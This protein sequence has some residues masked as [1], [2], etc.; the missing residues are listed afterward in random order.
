MRH[1]KILLVFGVMCFI[2][3]VSFAQVETIEEVK[4]EVQNKTKVLISDLPQAVTKTLKDKYTDYVASKASSSIQDN[5]TVTYIV[6]LLKDKET[7]KVTIDSE[8][9]VVEKY[10]AK[11]NKI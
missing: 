5:G 3:T 7:T 9:N 8:G 2:G 4:T 11:R 6:S 10:K 1:L